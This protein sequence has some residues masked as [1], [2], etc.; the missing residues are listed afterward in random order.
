M[1]YKPGKGQIDETTKGKTPLDEYEENTS[2]ISNNRENTGNILDDVDGVP[3][4]ILKEVEAGSG[5]VP[6]SFYTGPNAI[7][8]ADGGRITYS[9]GGLAAMLGE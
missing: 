3:D 5:N 7:K 2:Y 9:S 1:R 6:E 8:K 4:D